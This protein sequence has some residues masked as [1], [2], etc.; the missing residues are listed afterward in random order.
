[1]TGNARD[2][3]DAMLECCAL[4]ATA[5]L[6]TP[7]TQAEANVCSVAGMI[8]SRNLHEAGH[9]LT[10]AAAAYFAAHPAE[11]LE[12][13][14]TVRRGWIIGLPRFRNRLERMLRETADDAR[15]REQVPASIDDPRPSIPHELASTESVSRKAALRQVTDPAIM[16]ALYRLADYPVLAALVTRH[17]QATRLDGRACRHL[18]AQALDTM[19]VSWLSAQE[20]AF[21]RMLGVEPPGLE[22]LVAITREGEYLVARLSG[23]RVLRHKDALSLAD[24][25]SVEGVTADDVRSPDWRAGDTSVST[26]ERIA[27]LGRLR[28]VGQGPSP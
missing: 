28:K 15:F 3:E 1:M 16:H 26:G 18:Y 5:A 17:A 20:L 2:N 13:A 23:G 10:Q 8:L 6:E 22:S 24:L 27:I 9:R 11:L 12:S 7:R 4:I 21:M 19:D 14:E 25:L